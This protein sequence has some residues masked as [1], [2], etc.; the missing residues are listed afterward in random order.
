M[1]PLVVTVGSVEVPW[2]GDWS[3]ADVWY[4]M[5]GDG[6]PDGPIVRC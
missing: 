2:S 4:Q 3:I 6:L 5:V 1:I